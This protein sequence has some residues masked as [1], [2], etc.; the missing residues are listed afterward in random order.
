[1]EAITH[2]RPLD[3]RNVVR[4]IKNSAGRHQ[5][6]I[7]AASSAV[8]VLA[9]FLF[10]ETAPRIGLVDPIII[11]PLSADLQ[12]I[13]TMVKSGVIFNHIAASLGRAGLGFVLSL[14]VGITLGILIGWNVRIKDTLNPLLTIIAQTSPIA[15]F[16]FF[17]VV[18]GV[19]EVSKVGI[20]FWGCV[21]PILLN[22]ISGVGHT[23]PLLVKAVRTMGATNWQIIRRVVFPASL[24]EI[25]PG[26]KI[27]ASYAILMLCAAEMLG[28]KAGLGYLVSYSQHV[29]QNA[30]MYAAILL[31]AA[32]GV[33]VNY[34]L[35]KA[36][37][38]V[39]HYRLSA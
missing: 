25:F 6:V 18:F 39:C 30:N 10:W 8:P 16:P 22:T 2:E 23:D 17:I 32:L 14:L 27:S 12:A 35:L 9:F 19:G 21:W 4:E 11:P 7:K 1:M 20:I 31:I 37:K 38:Y 24:P 15:L 5:K 28:A 29:F 36:E 26:I 3:E 13:V 33:I 34:L